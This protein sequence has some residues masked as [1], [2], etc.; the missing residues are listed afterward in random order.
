M[1][2]C[3]YVDDLVIYYKSKTIDDIKENMQRNIN[4]A[5]NYAKENGLNFS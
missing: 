4:S 1:G 3:V 5:N 2:R